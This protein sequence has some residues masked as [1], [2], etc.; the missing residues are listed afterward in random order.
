MI[1]RVHQN[2]WRWDKCFSDQNDSEFSRQIK[3]IPHNQIL[4][5]HEFE[6][7]ELVKDG[8]LENNVITMKRVDFTHSQSSL[9]DSGVSIGL[10]MNIYPTDLQQVSIYSL[11]F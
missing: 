11:D 4:A 8:A 3:Q 5:K 6:I 9:G 7:A 10:L 2:C 1:K